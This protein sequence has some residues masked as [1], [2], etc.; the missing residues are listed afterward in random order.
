[1]PVINRH[2]INPDINYDGANRDDLFRLINRWKR[3]LIYKE[4]KH[5]DVMA[6]GIFD[7]NLNHIALLFAAAELGLKI[8]IIAKPIAKETLHVTKMALFGPIDITISQRMLEENDLQTEMFE[9][10][11][12]Q[13]C[14]E[15]EIDEVT[16]DM[17][18][19]MPVSPSDALIFASTS[20]TTGPSK[21]YFFTHDEVYKISQ[22]NISVF[23]YTKQS[24]VQQTVN[25]H[26]VSAMLTYLIPTLM[27]SDIHYSG[28]PA[29]FPH[30]AKK[31]WPPK[32]FV[33]ECLVDRKIDT[34]IC[35]NSFILE[36]IKIGMAETNKHPTHRIT[37]NMSG[38]PAGPDIYDM[39]KQY[40]VDF[41]SHYGSVDTGAPLLVNKIT[42]DS[43]YEPGYIGKL[44]DDFYKIDGDMVHSDLWSEP[45][46]VPD[47]L[48]VEGDR[49]YYGGRTDEHPLY[50]GE[51]RDIMQEQFGDHTF[52]VPNNGKHYI[53]LWDK[54]EKYDI[55]H[56]K[57]YLDTVF[58]FVYLNKRDF[59]VDTKISIEQL[60]AYLEHHYG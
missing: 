24:V 12:K 37:I 21:P 50:T 17:D 46:P 28:S 34:L 23:G 3:F 15:D 55:E 5:G 32:E 6:L 58:T 16:N 31:I 10:Y 26:H 35:A 4:I 30:H 20:G 56:G 52:V 38:F 9:R 25:M 33:E 11:S 48:I 18:V 14:Y 53:V 42:Q 57:T 47:T 2:I 8:F 43:V 29:W 49:F 39:T 7:V 40:P 19:E 44:P 54:T 45:R 51:L 41:I 59:M 22:R 60:R 36:I 1:M 13:V 27:V